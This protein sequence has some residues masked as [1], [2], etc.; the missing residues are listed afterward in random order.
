MLSYHCAMPTL[1][2]MVTYNWVKNSL[3]EYLWDVSELE[4]LQRPKHVT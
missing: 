4:L 3:D 1:V 2:A